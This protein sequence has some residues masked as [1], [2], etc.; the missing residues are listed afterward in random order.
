M[1]KLR[2]QNVALGK[3]QIR[4]FSFWKFVWPFSSYGEFKY[5]KI[6][7][8]CP[9]VA[10]CKGIFSAEPLISMRHPGVMICWKYGYDNFNEAGDIKIFIFMPFSPFAT[11]RSKTVLA[12]WVTLDSKMK[13]LWRCTKWHLVFENRLSNSPDLCAWRF[14]RSATSVPPSGKTVH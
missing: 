5:F 2:R 14:R 3:L 4:Q 10:K 1:I 13:N 7:I 9:L 6:C 11:Y 8:F 12:T